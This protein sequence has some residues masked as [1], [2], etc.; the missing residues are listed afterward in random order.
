MEAL[1]L[2]S[3]RVQDR[4]RS[5]AVSSVVKRLLVLNNRRLPSRAGKMEALVLRSCWV[6][7]RARSK[8]VSSNLKWQLAYRV[9]LGRWRP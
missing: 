4:T 2:R 8:A 1:A 6:Q 7:A 5:N 3:C 9:E